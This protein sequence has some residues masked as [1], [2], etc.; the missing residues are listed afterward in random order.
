MQGGGDKVDCNEPTTEKTQR[1]Y[2]GKQTTRTKTD[3]SRDSRKRTEL[4]KEC[5]NKE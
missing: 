2:F 4:R 1:K 5:G 3:S